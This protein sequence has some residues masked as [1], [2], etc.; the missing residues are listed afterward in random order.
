MSQALTS[1]SFCNMTG[2]LKGG[3]RY[4]KVKNVGVGG[5]HVTPL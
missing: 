1:V 2:D 4:R 5:E 3:I